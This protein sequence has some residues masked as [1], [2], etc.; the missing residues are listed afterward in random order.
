MT[1]LDSEPEDFEPI[2]MVGPDDEM[3]ASDWA[4]GFLDAVALRS[5][6][7]EPLIAHDSAGIMM[8]FL[9]EGTVRPDIE[10][11]CIA[12]LLQS[13]STRAAPVP[14]SGQTAPKTQLD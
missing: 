6:A 3:I 2:F 13:G 1:C 14:R 12:P 5:S 8:G 9:I 7:W 11:S 10:F 4:A